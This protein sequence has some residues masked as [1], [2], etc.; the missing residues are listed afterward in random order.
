M[1]RVKMWVNTIDFTA[2]L[3]YYKSCLM[4]EAKTIILSKVVL[5]VCKGNI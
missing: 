1:E 2:S 3:K 5:T 4:A